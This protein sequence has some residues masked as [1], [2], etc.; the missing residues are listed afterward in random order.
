MENKK[1]NMTKV[2][3]AAAA[4]AFSMAAVGCSTSS[5]DTITSSLGMTASNKAATVAMRP[6]LLDLIMPKAHALTPSAIVDSVGTSIALSSAWVVIKEVEFEATETPGA[7]EVDGA[8]ISFRGPYFV[9]LLSNAP[10][11]LDSQVVPAGGFQRIKMKLEKAGGAAVPASAPAAL[12]SNSI[13]VAG[14]LGTGGASRVFVF[15][16]DDG[17]ELN[18][19]GP[20]AVTPV[21]GGQVLVEINFSDIFKQI[22]MSTVANNEVIS[23]SNRHAAANLCPNI[24][25]SAN[26]IYTCMRKGLEKHADVGED[27]DHSG[28]LDATENKVK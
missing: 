6:S 20:A 26:D 28:S 23:S 5:T 7:D 11:A 4:M 18:V 12:G 10:T 16:F 25:A 21:D 2:S 1:L 22:D 17:T 3:C 13:Y 9:D 27:S 19:G 15:Q 8:E 14:T 24:D